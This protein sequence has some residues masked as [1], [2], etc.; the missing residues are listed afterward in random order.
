MLPPVVARPAVAVRLVPKRPPDPFLQGRY[1]V[2]RDPETLTWQTPEG[3][4]VKQPGQLT[5]HHA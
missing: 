2:R 4:A 5:D 3:I 1:H